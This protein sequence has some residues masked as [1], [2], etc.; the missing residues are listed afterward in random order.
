M[1]HTRNP[2]LGMALKS[3]VVVS[4]KS[5]VQKEK[6]KKRFVPSPLAPGMKPLQ[7]RAANLV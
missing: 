7:I 2:V 4:F 3:R 6:K 1:K 5:G